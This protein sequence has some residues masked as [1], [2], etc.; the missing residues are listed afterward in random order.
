MTETEDFIYNYY[1]SKSEIM[2]YKVSS[3]ELNINDKFWYKMPFDNSKGW[4]CI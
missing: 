1:D 4:I 2:L 3:V